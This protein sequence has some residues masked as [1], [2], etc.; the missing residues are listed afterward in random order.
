MHDPYAHTDPQPYAGVPNPCA[1]PIWRT[2]TFH[3]TSM[4][5]IDN[6]GHNQQWWSLLP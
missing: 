1:S 3:G 6:G 4:H 2:F 5:I